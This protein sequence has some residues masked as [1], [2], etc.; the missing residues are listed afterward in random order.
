M[1]L[2]INNQQ[3]E[4]L[5]TKLGRLENLPLLKPKQANGL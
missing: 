5:V 2:Y 4:T 3:K 1:Y